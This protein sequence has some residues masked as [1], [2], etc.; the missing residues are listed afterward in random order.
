M[1]ALQVQF[2]QFENIPTVVDFQRRIMKPV[3]PHARN[4]LRSTFGLGR[5]SIKTS[6]CE[7]EDAKHRVLI[8]DSL[9]VLKR[10]L[11]PQKVILIYNR[12]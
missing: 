5:F 11:C 7:V 6:G 8:G 3:D 2:A 9:V 10:A 4:L 1:I 12:K